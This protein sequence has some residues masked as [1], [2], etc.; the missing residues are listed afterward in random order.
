MPVD[1][2]SVP[3]S[4]GLHRLSDACYAWLQPGGGFCLNNAGLVVSNGE[5]LLI[6]TLTDIKRTREML[7]GMAA[8]VPAA[9]RIDQLVNTHGDLDHTAG[10]CLL[11]DTRRIMSRVGAAHY[12]HI[13]Q[14]VDRI[15]ASTG[16]MRQLMNELGLGTTFDP[17]G[18]K[19][20]EP[21]LTFDGYLE[22]PVGSISAHC[23]E[24][25]PAHNRSDTVVHVADEGVVY[26]GDLMFCNCHPVLGF[27]PV[28]NWVVACDAL[29]GWN[30]EVFVPGHGPVA[31]PAEVRRHRD[32]VIL[33]HEEAR[34]RYAR[35]MS[36]DEA[37]LDIFDTFEEFR[38]LLRADILRKNVNVVYHELRNEPMVEN[39][40]AQSIARWLFR[41]R[42]RGRARGIEIGH[43]PD[44]N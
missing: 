11:H 12:S 31:G 17:R 40:E 37:A 43:V 28:E 23:H 34:A 1:P 22:V 13:E 9:A 4:H 33:L 5:T 7:E 38:H 42:I 8:A 32:Y 25:G 26:A 15:L 16:E 18:V 2:A 41:E 27:W 6:D 20:I 14:S 24:F 10:N 36:V 29:L 39:V 21:T 44:G 30:A 35:G 3:F 19:H